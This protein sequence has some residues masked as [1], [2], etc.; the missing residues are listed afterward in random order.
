MSE[1]STLICTC[2]LVNGYILKNFFNFIPLRARPTITF[3]NDRII[4]SNCT[5][6]KQIYGTGYLHGDE[7]NLIWSNDVPMDQRKLSL[8]FDSSQNPLTFGGIKK[9]DEARLLIA[10]RNEPGAEKNY[11]I[12]VSCG[13]GGDRR[14][15]VQTISAQQVKTEEFL[16][17]MPDPAKATLLS[18][19]IQPFRKM[20]TAFNKCRKQT[21]RLCFYP[22]HQFIE[23]VEH[24]GP[25]GITIRT[26]MVGG[27]RTGPILE[28]YG[29]VPNE[30]VPEASPNVN[31]MLDQIADIDERTIVRTQ[32][33]EVQLV[34]VEEED[35]G[36]NEFVFDAD[37]ISVFNRLATMHNEGCVRI[38]YQPGC[39][40]RIAYRCGGF[41]ECELYLH[42]KYVRLV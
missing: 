11:T 27:G 38:Y 24:R 5:A 8:T 36:P 16:V 17:R 1:T 6:D 23:G 40:L 31:Y 3:L 9:K 7:I 10:Q 19:P 4:A 35:N 26:D 34:L 42:N 15:G 37:K 2:E 30:T 22:N 33:S 12:F 39:H 18:I 41:G 28:K 13:E 29:E 14:E 20:I 21:I 25:P 32:S